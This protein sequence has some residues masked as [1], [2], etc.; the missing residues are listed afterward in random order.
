MKKFYVITSILL[1]CLCFIS[2]QVA[3]QN[4]G[5]ANTT[6]N[7]P[8]SFANLSGSK[9]DLF[10]NSANSRYGFGI[11]S[12]LFQMFSNGPAADIALGHGSS[13]LFTE[14]M[15]IKGNG[16][17]GIGITTP[18]DAGLIVDK[19]VGAVNAMFGRNT[20][21]IAIESNNPGIGFNSYYNGGRKTISIGYTGLIS[22][23]PAVGNLILYNSNLSSATDAAA[24]ITSRLLID[25][26]GDIGIEGNTAPHVPLSFANTSGSKISLFGS[27]ETSN[28]GF[29]IQ[30]SLLQMYSS[31]ST[32]DI[33]F[34]YGGSTAFTENMRIKGNGNVGI[35]ETNPGAKLHIFYN[36][37]TTSPHLRLLENDN[38]GPARIYLG[39]TAQ[40]NVYWKISAANSTSGIFSDKFIIGHSSTLVG[41]AG[42]LLTLTG[43]G[44]VGIANISPSA[45]LGFE[46]TVGNKIDLFW[47]AAN[48]RYGLGVQ[49]GLLQIY[50]SASNADI[51]FGYGSST[52]F[53]E[54]MR[55]KGT[56]NVGIGN[57]DAAFPLDITGR[58]RLRHVSGTTPGIWFNK[59]DN[60]QG[61]FL[62]QVDANNLG[63]WGP[64]AAGSY[65]FLFDGNDGTLRIGTQLKATGY[66]VNVGGKI[67]AEEVR[68][69][70]QASWPDYVFKEN[71]KL[72][73]LDEVEAFID[74]NDHL[75]GFNKA[76]VIEKQGSD[77]GETQRLLVEKVE[78]LTLYVIQLKKEI[79]A[80]KGNK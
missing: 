57:T 76:D 24:T 12:G 67:I 77:L 29:G 46:N 6:P 20:T 80:L 7:A 40:A 23:E 34:G 49:S 78:E 36:S 53:T 22:F 31:I 32:S 60:T 64:G 11:Q 9:I 2:L 68:V 47:T 35:G 37:S 43:S 13:S 56:G 33:A 71:Y 16:N 42:D 70:L 63:I 54:R 52:S 65:K 1:A 66:L 62:G 17:V 18:D 28:Y 51:A 19:K 39:N 58:L 38:A 8:L 4:V 74:A 55:I 73:P 72:M 26:D 25:K 5:I 10:Y 61:T 48:A 69:Q 3:A 50:S 79:E 15:R 44:N 41:A 45:P 21:G 75:P 27:T 30:S 14:L 59:P